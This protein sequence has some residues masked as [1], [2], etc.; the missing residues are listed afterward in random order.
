[1]TGT[2]HQEHTL[3]DPTV[4]RKVGLFFVAVIGV[5]FLLAHYN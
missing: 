3:E 4:C 2:T 1:M 5:L